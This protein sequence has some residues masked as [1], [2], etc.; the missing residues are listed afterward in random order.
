MASVET[1][2]LTAA[3]RQR[4]HAVLTRLRYG[5]PGAPRVKRDE[6]TTVAD[7]VHVL[8]ALGLALIVRVDEA[9]ATRRRLS[10]IEADVAAMRRVLGTT[11]S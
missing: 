2:E 11:A 4:L 10:E 5:A 6:L 7:V 9:I 3:D 1:A 8:D